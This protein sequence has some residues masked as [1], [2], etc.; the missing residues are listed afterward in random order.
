MLRAELASLVAWPPDLRLLLWVLSAFSDGSVNVDRN[1]PATIRSTFAARGS[2]RFLGHVG[3]AADAGGSQTH[4]VDVRGFVAIRG[5]SI[6][7][8]SPG[9]MR[10][11]DLNVTVERGQLHFVWMAL[12]RC[13]GASAEG[14]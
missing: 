8:L 2:V 5:L 4:L 6:A 1:P 11:C 7:R 10:F 13:P 3:D 12:R 14:K 9:Q